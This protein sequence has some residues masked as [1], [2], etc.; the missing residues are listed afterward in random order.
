MNGGRGNI[1]VNQFRKNNPYG[2]I[3]RARRWWQS[4]RL[5]TCGQRVW[6]D[7]GVR[8]LR[9]PQGIHLGNEVALKEGTHLCSCNKDASITVGA[10]T[11]IGHYTF[12]YASGRID[13]GED[14]MIAPFVYIVDSDHET[15]RDR[16]MN[17]QSNRVAPVRIGDDVWIATGAKILAGVTIGQG[18]VI[19]AGAV[20]NDDV[21]PNA[22]AGGVPARLIGERT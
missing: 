3:H 14:C 11:T 7:Q 20:V 4:L 2:L 10:R 17:Q 16:P 12:I 19:A 6:I 13:I 18:A 5:G 21:P 22:V 15:A 1:C 8:L 9:F